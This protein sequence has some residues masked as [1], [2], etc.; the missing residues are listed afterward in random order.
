M[1][2]KFNLKTPRR[3]SINHYETL[4]KK[5]IIQKDTLSVNLYFFPLHKS[6]KWN[7]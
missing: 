4:Y 5:E 6:F 1:K 3:K 2:E 7:V